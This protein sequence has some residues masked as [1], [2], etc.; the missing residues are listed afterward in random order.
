MIII[1]IY[2]LLLH[3]GHLS[4]FPME[5]NPCYSR[6]YLTC[7]WGGFHSIHG[8]PVCL[9]GAFHKLILLQFVILSLLQAIS[10]SVFF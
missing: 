8:D 7:F 6:A 10:K 1:L 4:E 9:R 2:P 5:G 3:K